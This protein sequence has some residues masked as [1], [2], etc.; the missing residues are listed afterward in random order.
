MLPAWTIG[1][2]MK[3][4]S[5]IPTA[6]EAGTKLSFKFNNGSHSAMITFTPPPAGGDVRKAGSYGPEPSVREHQDVLIGQLIAALNPVLFQRM[7]DGDAT[8]TATDWDGYMAELKAA[9]DTDEAKQVGYFIKTGN[10]GYVNNYC[11][12]LSKNGSVYAKTNCISRTRTAV[13]FIASELTQKGKVNKAAS[14]PAA[15]LDAMP[16]TLEDLPF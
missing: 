16:G 3:L 8:F 5:I 12:G 7:I 6:T 15:D 4:I 1:E 9:L 11:A 2:G 14:A 13:E 10:K